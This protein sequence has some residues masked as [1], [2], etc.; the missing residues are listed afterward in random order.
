MKCPLCSNEELHYRGKEPDGS[1]IWFCEECSRYVTSEL[2]REGLSPD[3]PTHTNE[4]G[5]MQSAI[6]YAFHLLD[7]N[8]LLDIAK[9]FAE[10]AEKYARDNWRKITCEEHINHIMTH[11][12]AALS[13]DK[14]D[15]HLEHAGAR[16][17][18]ALATKND[19]S[20]EKRP[21]CIQPLSLEN[22]S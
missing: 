21:E 13:G 9:V 10:G 16:V 18:M 4:K 15:D 6:P 14:Q 17:I 22:D 8:A 1:D 2:V 19:G 3:T 12:W 5:G 11:L 7:A 20:L